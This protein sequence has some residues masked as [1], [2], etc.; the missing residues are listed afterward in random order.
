MCAKKCEAELKSFFSEENKSEKNFNSSFVWA[1]RKSKVNGSLE[2]R[3]R[4]LVLFFYFI[5]CSSKK[6]K[7][8]EIQK[9]CVLGKISKSQSVHKSCFEWKFFEKKISLSSKSQEKSVTRRND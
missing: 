6:K 3:E 1:S 2:S 7:K 5:L 4:V 8:R 9:F